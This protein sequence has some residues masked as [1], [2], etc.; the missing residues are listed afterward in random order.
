M[1]KSVTSFSREGLRDWLLQRVTAV[2]LGIYALVIVAYL[3]RH[4][5][6][7]FAD[8]SLLYKPVWMKIF[9]ILAIFSIL[10]HAWIGMWTVYTDY[11]KCTVVRLVLQ[12][13]TILGLFTLVVWALMI[14]WG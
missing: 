4:Y 7:D 6:L 5:P 13:A 1:V 2:L 14:I 8:W 3:F 9:S 11:I 10:I 12:I